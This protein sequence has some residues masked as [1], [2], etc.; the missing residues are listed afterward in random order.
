MH[1]KMVV[2]LRGELL[3][4]PHPAKSRFLTI[5]IAAPAAAALIGMKTL[6]CTHGT[7]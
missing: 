3:Y 5:D 4:L 6:E 2:L 7:Q 1:F